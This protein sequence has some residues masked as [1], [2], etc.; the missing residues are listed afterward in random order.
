MKVVIVTG[1]RRGIGAGIAERFLAE[2]C[3]VVA[4]DMSFDDGYRGGIIL[5]G[6]GS[7]SERSEFAAAPTVGG[8]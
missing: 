7:L 6:L 4:A 8:P 1:A 5:V 2:G 3:T